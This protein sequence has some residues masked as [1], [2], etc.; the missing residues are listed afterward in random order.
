M[1]SIRIPGEDVQGN[2]A[3]SPAPARS[4]RRLG[5]IRLLALLLALTILGAGILGFFWS[6]EPQPF[7]PRATVLTRP[8]GEELV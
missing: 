1:A 3:P 7:D 8:D 5:G 6:R 4:R 2:T